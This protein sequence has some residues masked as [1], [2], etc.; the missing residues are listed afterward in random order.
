MHCA[1]CFASVIIQSLLDHS[2]NKQLL[3]AY[4]S[5]ATCVRKGDGSSVIIHILLIRGLQLR[6]LKAWA[7][8]VGKR[9]GGGGG[10]FQFQEITYSLGASLSFFF[11]FLLNLIQMPPLI[12]RHLVS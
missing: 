3:R 2:F 8:A 7:S 10:S 6:G 5:V 11:F 1:K 9:L 4:N 12:C